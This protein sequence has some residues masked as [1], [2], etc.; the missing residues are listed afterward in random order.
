MN[1][2]ALKKLEEVI[3]NWNRK[4]IYP[5]EIKNVIAFK[6]PA[7]Q[8]EYILHFENT[9]HKLSCCGQLIQTNLVSKPFLTQTLSD[10]SLS[11]NPMA[12]KNALEKML[13]KFDKDFYER[14]ETELN[15][16]FEKLI[17]PSLLFERND[18]NEQI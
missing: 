4:R 17:M 13:D 12:D 18:I 7:A 9:V 16:C 1:V 3:V 8:G 2:S 14:I 11:E 6:N 10:E 15:N 5:Y